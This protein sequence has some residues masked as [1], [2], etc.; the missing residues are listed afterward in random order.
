MPLGLDIFSYLLIAS[1]S[2]SFGFLLGTVLQSGKVSKLY[3]RLDVSKALVE[4]QAQQLREL[5]LSNRQLARES[6]DRAN[7]KAQVSPGTSAFPQFQSLEMTA[8]KTQD[9]PV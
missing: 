3:R 2:A 6:V 7:R 4:D 8:E 5:T 1:L 9:S